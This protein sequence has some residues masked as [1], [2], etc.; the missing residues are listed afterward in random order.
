M[1]DLDWLHGE[2]SAVRVYSEATFERKLRKELRIPDDPLPDPW[3]GVAPVD[4]L[5]LGQISDLCEG[6]GLSPRQ[7]LIVL[8]RAQGWTVREIAAHLE[9]RRQSVERH[10]RCIREALG[11]SLSE[12]ENRLPPGAVPHYGWQQTYLDSLRRR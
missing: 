11:E 10:Y 7:R 2:D 4:E 1:L 12:A 3:G 6:L 8:L 9:I 5:L